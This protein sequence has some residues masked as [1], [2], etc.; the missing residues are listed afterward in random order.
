MTTIVE[1]NPAARTASAALTYRPDI[2]GMR[3]VAVMLVLIFHFSLVTAAKAGFL[4][5][6]VF[7]VISGFLI[8]AILTRQLDAGQISLGAFYVNRIRRLAPALL[9]VLLLVMAAGCLW[10]FPNEL[11]ELSKQ[12]LAAQ[13]YVANI[14][15]WRNTSYFGL[16]AHN[17]FLLHTWSLAVEEQFYL[18]YPACLLLLHR[19]MKKYFWTA[20]ALGFLISFA[21]N[22]LFVSQK[23]DATFYLFPTRAWELLMGALVSLIAVKWACSR[24]VDEMMALLGAALVVIGVA[25]YR[26]DFHIPGYYA[27]LPTTGAACL[28]LS[29]QS[30]ATIIS[31][32]LSL[33]PIVYIGKISYS[34]YLVHWPINVFAGLVIEHYSPGWRLAM[35]ALSIGLAALVYHVVEEPVH[36]KRYFVTKTKLLLGYATGLAGTVS[37]FA[38]VQLAGGLPQRFPD[39]VVRLANYVN[40][41]TPPLTECGFHGQ[42]LV[43]ARSLCRIGAPGQDPTWL[44]YGDSHAWALHAAFDKWLKLNGQTGLFIFLYRCPPL[45]GVYL[46][47]DVGKD[48]CFA[49]NQAVTRFIESHADLSNIVLASIWQEAMGGLLSTSPQTRLTREEQ[50]KLFTD[51][52]SQ[53]LEH[54]HDLGRHIY[55]W[56]PVPGARTPTSRGSSERRDQPVPLELARAAWEGKPADIEGDLAEYLL[57]NQFFFD[58]LRNNR[59]WIT[60]SFSPSEVLCSTGKCIVEYD[61]APLYFDH[62][63]PSK[64]TV[65]FWVRVL[66]R[67]LQQGRA[68]GS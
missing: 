8:T 56:E 14:Y 61:G 10:L 23:P 42:P 41:R 67:G 32:A 66:Q 64:S 50:L 36:H 37:V 57:E 45:S 19:Y 33:R 7:F 55:I 28:I 54:L 6:D 5:V 35:F 17:V 3:A 15:Y 31:R 68:H 34:L 27:L 1:V 4:G 65:D 12:A 46:F 48:S 20:I 11:L 39:E 9:V 52:F 22:T 58:A 24:V 53:T 49:F 43:S 40:D 25:C 26:Q 30:S 2:D 62:V 51:R 21:L 47:G 63:H 38:V 16:D 44:V 59:R 18:I 29:G 60:A 13:L